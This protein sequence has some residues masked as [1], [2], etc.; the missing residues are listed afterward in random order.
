MEFLFLRPFC[1]CVGRERFYQHV[2]ADKN[3]S[4]ARPANCL[5]ILIVKAQYNIS[6]VPMRLNATQAGYLFFKAHFRFAHGY[7]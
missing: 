2:E 7:A 5:R 4:R 3:K 6:Q 1:P